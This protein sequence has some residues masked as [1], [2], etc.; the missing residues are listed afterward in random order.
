MSLPAGY[1]IRRA[2]KSDYDGI[3]SVLKVLTTVGNV[4]KEDFDSV[5]EHW[6]SVKIDV[7]RHMYNCT[8]ITNEIGEVVATGSL[9][10]ERKVIHECGLVGHIEDIAVR[11]DQQGKKLGL[12]LIQYLYKLAKESGCYKAI[13]DC[14]E[15]NVGFYEKCGL[16][17]AGVEMQIRFGR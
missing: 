6:D 1:S 9:I 4:K 3:T 10:I 15:K 13:L 12:F 11:E 5:V 14:D 17:K 7:S 16:Q 2:T 8:V